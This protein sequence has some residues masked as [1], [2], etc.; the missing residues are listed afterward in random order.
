MMKVFTTLIITV[1]LVRVA[2]S[3][4]CS[5]PYIPLASMFTPEY[6]EDNQLVRGRFSCQDGFIGVGVEEIECQ[7]GSW[8]ETDFNCCSN[9]AVNKPS[10]Y[11]SNTSQP[12][13]ALPLDGQVR[14]DSEYFCDMMDR[15]NRVWSVD[16]GESVTVIGVNLI[17]HSTGDTIKNIEVLGL[18]FDNLNK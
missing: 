7:N 3:Q 9:V 4:Q 11:N 14:L 6:D 13:S 17:T 2:V 16:L 10:F 8:D 18:Y 12:G 15:S 5:M 1:E